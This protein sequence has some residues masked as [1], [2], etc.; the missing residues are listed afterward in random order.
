ML[1]WALVGQVE[2]LPNCQSEK[3]DNI[4]ENNKVS[5]AAA[6]S[7]IVLKVIIPRHKETNIHF[8]EIDERKL[9]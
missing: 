1:I 9:T 8:S 5:A 7:P 4:I 6:E 3:N 2:P